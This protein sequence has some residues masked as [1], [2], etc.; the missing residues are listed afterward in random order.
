MTQLIISANLGH[1]RVLHHQNAGDH[2]CQQPHWL[3]SPDA[4]WQQSTPPLRE[5]VTDQAGRF[6]QGCSADRQ[7]GMSIG[8]EHQLQREI[9]LNSLKHIASHIET[10]LHN[11]GW[12]DWI[13]AAPKSILPALEHSLSPDALKHLQDRVGA[14]LTRCPIG[15]IQERFPA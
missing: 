9:D 1:I 10:I 11:Q 5:R 12:P 8:E 3:E 7:T 15:E 14:D 13:L 6:A 2:P 4:N